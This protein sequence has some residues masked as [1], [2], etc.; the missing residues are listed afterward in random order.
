MEAERSLLTDQK[1]EEERARS[2]FDALGRAGLLP[3]RE[4]TA[5]NTEWS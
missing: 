3:I 5:S 2:L 4:P 1:N